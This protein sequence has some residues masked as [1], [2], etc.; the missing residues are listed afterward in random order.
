LRG[1]GSLSGSQWRAKRHKRQH[2]YLEPTHATRLSWL[3]KGGEALCRR[4]RIARKHVSAQAG[5]ALARAPLPTDGLGDA[6]RRHSSKQEAP[7]G[8]Q[9]TRVSRLA[10][11]F[12]RMI[13]AHPYRPCAVANDACAALRTASMIG[14]GPQ[15]NR[16]G[17]RLTG[18]A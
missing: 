5:L 7:V 3:S 10:Q 1:R 6:R 11:D 16:A 2:G 12:A 8:V 15:A 18:G 13:K 9:N 4:T 17:T 14:G